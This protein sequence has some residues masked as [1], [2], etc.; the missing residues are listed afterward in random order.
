MWISRLE[1]RG[2]AGAPSTPMSADL[3]RR[4]L[5]AAPWVADAFALLS[6][7]LS[8]SARPA[9]LDR[10]GWSGTFTDD[11]LDLGRVAPSVEPAPHPALVVEAKIELDP[12]LFGR[13]REGVIRNPQLAG[14]LAEGTLTV[15]IGW[16]FTPD[17]RI[18]RH[19]VL[20]LALGTVAVPLAEL[21]AWWS[22]V[23]QRVGQQIAV[24]GAP[25]VSAHAARI[26]RALLGPD[27]ELRERATALLA[28][29]DWA[30]ID[31]DEHLSVR[32]AGTLHPLRWRGPAEERRFQLATV[33]LLDQPDVLVWAHGLTPTIVEQLPLWL[34]GDDAVLEQ[35]VCS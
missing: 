32:Q 9:L 34:D 33:A 17:R 11:E 30:L 19:D 23:L 8:P 1:A 4:T 16:A 31:D 24:P 15:R 20:G 27:P 5:D 13:L 7:A 22:A 14:G 29:G 3:E 6:A 28:Q 26:R 21:P 25:S 12:P 18:V 2:F 10:F 35:A